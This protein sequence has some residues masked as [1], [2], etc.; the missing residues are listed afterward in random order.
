M[1]YKHHKEDIIKA[2]TEVLHTKGYT[3]TGIND[4]LQAANVSK[5]SFY[6]F[7]DSKE[8]FC[9]EALDYY[10]SMNN[11]MI[12]SVLE[13]PNK[14]AIQKLES[15]YYE[16]LL[17]ANKLSHCKKGCLV[18]NLSLELG[19]TIEPIAKKAADLFS[20]SVSIIARCIEEG[21]KQ[22]S[23]RDDY[24][25]LQLAEF[26]HSNISGGIARSKATGDIKYLKSVIDMSMDFIK[27]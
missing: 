4:I 5:G 6:N 16:G 11:N 17:M 23:I 12:Q 19:G 14:T 27:I 8:S 25:A 18:N 21:Q 13:D 2:G 22:K 26:F 10:G 3:A 9:I 20:Q 24:S 15:F 7:F 1:G